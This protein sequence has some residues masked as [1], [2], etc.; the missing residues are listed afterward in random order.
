MTDELTN[1]TLVFDLFGVIARHQSEAGCARI[2]RAA[3]AVGPTLGPTFWKAYWA[4]RPQYDS[5]DQQGPEYW[6]AVATELDLAYT[7]E[8]IADLVAADLDSWSEIDEDMV[9]FVGELRHRGARLALLSNI[10]EELAAHYEQRHEWLAAFSVLALSCR[11]GHAKPAVE[12]FQWC[13][14][15]LE[16]EPAD[17]LF[18]DDRAENVAAAEAV[19]MRGH[20]FTSL[21]RLRAAI[22]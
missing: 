3:G 11:I 17:L 22:R 4:L 8:Q 18:I 9:A 2:E 10:P 12:A 1:S 19:G 5:G 21:D 20:L 15:A 16:S 13:A 6:R 14:R 7:D